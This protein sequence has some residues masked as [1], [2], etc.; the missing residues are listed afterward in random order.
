MPPEGMW[1]VRRESYI[2]FFKM[3]FKLIRLIF[4]SIQV[5]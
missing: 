3:L 4:D 1:L 2:H 5:I